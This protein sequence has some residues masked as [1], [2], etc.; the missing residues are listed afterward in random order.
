MKVFIAGLQNALELSAPA[1]DVLLRSQQ[2]PT[3]TGPSNWFQLSGHPDAFAPA[4]P[5]TVWKKCSGG[6]ERD[7]YEALSSDPALR[8]ITPA[9][10]RY[11]ILTVKSLF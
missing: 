7:V 5:G 10:F 1:S 2:C 6:D 8:D 9:Y 4:G 11:C 3:P